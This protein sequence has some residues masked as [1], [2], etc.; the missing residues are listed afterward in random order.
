MCNDEGGQTYMWLSCHSASEVPQ[1]PQSALARESA[2]PTGSAKTSKRWTNLLSP[3]AGLS[4]PSLGGF[5]ASVLERGAESARGPWGSTSSGG[6][7]GLPGSLFLMKV[8]PPAMPPP[9]GE[10]NPDQCLA[11]G[12]SCLLYAGDQDQIGMCGCTSTFTASARG[13]GCK[14]TTNQGIQR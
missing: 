1:L 9:G 14:Q 7:T 8:G 5:G 11:G 10:E 6:N 13:V 2:L 4:P 3:Q 12:H